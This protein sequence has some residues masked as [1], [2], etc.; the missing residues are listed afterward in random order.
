MAGAIGGNTSYLPKV[1]AGLIVNYS[2]NPK[3]F[4][5]NELVKLTPVD[6][7]IGRFP[8]LRPQEA[9]RLLGADYRRWS[10]GGNRP[11]SDFN[12]DQW[13]FISYE[14]RRWGEAIPM[15][16]LGIE[17]ADFPVVEAQQQSLAMRAM[18]F[19][20][21]SFYTVLETTGNYLSGHNDTATNFGSGKW[22]VATTSNRYIQN[23]LYAVARR[24]EKSTVGAVKMKDLT[25][26]VSPT[27]AMQMAAAP[28]IA[29]G[30]IQS[31]FALG[32]ISGDAQVN[33]QYGLPE[34]LYGMK[35][36]VDPT[37]EVSTQMNTSAT[38]TADYVAS[39]TTAYVIARPG[40]LVNNSG[41]A[42]DF[43]S[44]HCFVYK[45]EEMLAE[46]LDDPFNKRKVAALTDNFEMKWVAGESTVR[47]T[48]CVD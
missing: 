48:A 34:T 39:A 42:S 31:P 14:T 7:Q 2:R 6:R 3:D 38:A 35:L 41:I 16:Y 47:I 28:E 23:T 36:R 8:K 10:D 25:L 29:E 13:E 40:D 43:S 20:A 9:A 15:G 5:V 32:Q 18:L 11:V 24:I 44:V 27:I 46:L 26:V 21:K 22:D 1:A 17:Q 37:I 19:R 45:S 30:L 12:K 4:L 33:K